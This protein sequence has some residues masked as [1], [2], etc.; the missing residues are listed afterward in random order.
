MIKKSNLPSLVEVVIEHRKIPT[1]FSLSGI[2]KTYNT[3]LLK[4][5]IFL[6]T[7]ISIFLKMRLLNSKTNHQ[8]KNIQKDY[9]E[10]QYGMI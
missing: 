5:I 8:K 4:R 1:N 7:S 10:W 6:K 9:A 3:P 2:K